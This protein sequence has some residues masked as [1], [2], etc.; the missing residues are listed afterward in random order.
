MLM[1]RLNRLLPYV[2]LATGILA[3]VE[4][5]GRLGRFV[6]KS[7]VLGWLA[8][9]RVEVGWT[10]AGL[11]AIAW[12]FV[13][14]GA[15]R[16][17]NRLPKVLSERRWLMDILD[18]LT[19]RAELERRMAEQAEPIFVDAE[20]LAAALRAKVVGQDQICI[21]LAA[22]IRRRLALK[23]R[24]K[25]VGVFLFA[26]PPGAGKTWLGKVL[27]EA[28]GRKLLH[29]DMTQFSAGGHGATSLFGAAKGYVGSTEYGKLTAALRDT[30]DA[31]VLL[32]E[33]EKAHGDVH[34]NFL[35]AWN[36]G[37]VTEKSDGKQ[38]STTRAV[39]IA[40]TNAAVDT[41]ADL[42]RQYANDPDELRRAAVGT[43]REAGFA[44]EVLNR[45]DRIF[46]FEPLAGLDIARVA[47]LEI[48]RMI[49]GYG[50]TVADGGI[51]AQVLLDL[52]SRQQRMGAA[53]SSR[54]LTRAIEESVADSLIAAKEKGATAITLVKSDDG[55][56]RAEIAAPLTAGAQVQTQAQ[57]GS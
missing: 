27:A 46:V 36:D 28:L 40:T 53:A 2:F 57:R 15:L 25:P 11:A 18:R 19:N 39:F 5:A 44:P 1:A 16:R 8:H 48:E 20:A 12:L 31:V 55:G 7:G 21:D 23:Q 35:T 34:K 41:L 30:P 50:L 52:M 14:L 17:H 9:H 42:S 22:Q 6:G 29:F 32:D 38:I 51:D 33:I 13:L 56:V 4:L 54:D 43:L 45:I 10:I 37:F 49:A 47:A 24:G 26:G 3:I